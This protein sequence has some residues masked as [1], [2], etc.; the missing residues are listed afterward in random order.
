MDVHVM[1]PIVDIDNTGQQSKKILD[2]CN[3]KWN[4]DCLSFEKNKRNVNTASSY[5]VRQPMY[6]ESIDSWKGYEKYLTELIKIL[7]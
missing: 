3:L 4:K 7:N 6:K 5:Q 1:T 2:F